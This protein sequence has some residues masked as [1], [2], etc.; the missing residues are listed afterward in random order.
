MKNNLI[1][2]IAGWK[3]TALLALVAMVA[4]V[5]FSGVLTSTQSADASIQTAANGTGS[6][7]SADA[8]N[9][10]TLYILNSFDTGFVRFE[11]ETTGAA[12][13]TFT[14]SD[15]SDNGQSILCR[16]AATGV[17]SCDADAGGTGVTVALKISDDAGRGVIFVKQTTV[18]A[19]GTPTVTTDTISVTVA[20]VPSSLS[21]TPSPASINSG[22]GALADAGMTT[23]IVRLTD[24]DGAGIGG[25]SLTIIAS[26]GTLAQV[27][28]APTTWT[29][30]TGGTAFA[31]GGAQ[32]G[33][34]STSTDGAA[35][36]ADGAGY[37]AVTLTGGGVPA[38]A[39][40]TVRMTAGALSGVADVTM[41][42][43]ATD[44]TAEAEQS[45]IAVSESTFIV[46]TVVDSGGNAVTGA[47][48]A[49]KAQGGVVPPAKL[50]VAVATSGMTN[51][52]PKQD[53]VLA[54]LGDIPSCTV[55]NREL[56]AAVDEPPADAVPASV[57][58]G[59][60]AA[61]KCVIQVTATD[62]PGAAPDAARGTH[63]ITVAGYKPAGAGD[64]SVEIQVG[65]APATIEHDAPERIDPSAELTVSLTVLDDEDV[66]VGKV[67]IEVLHTAGDGAII[68]NIAGGATSDGR[69]AFTYIAP[70]TPG[71]VE[72]LVR[73]KAANGAVTSQQPIIVAIGAAP[74]EAPDAPP[75][76]WSAPL[77]SGTH[78]LVWNGDDGADA[79]D[80]AAEGVTAIWQWNG[81]GW[82]G[83]FPAAADVPGGNTLSS[84]TN[85][86]AY[87]VVVE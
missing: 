24:T 79:T 60:D 44:I 76:T 39:T 12:E 51:K 42:G 73:T 74:E 26:H 63:T 81:T 84:L 11:I 27:E 37:A 62:N 19:T 45:A 87:W 82:D 25:E 28:A 7:T 72:F 71:V 75:A 59:T 32:V 10:D 31:S 15:A 68:S 18:P 2:A 53:G 65:G 17:V 38:V 49:L 61:G 50:A 69:T 40:V 35:E 58:T 16:S 5:A 46:V 20:Q 29:D 86:A 64:V 41:F 8:N 1:S 77:A 6:D 21:V 85:G 67:T 9:G 70:S 80:G 57:S 78:N 33:S 52:D 56:V 22:Q 66:R 43:P 14:H 3:S 4:A 13:A 55:H 23:I 54:A 83:Y 30:A 47:V 34:I 36:N 48:P